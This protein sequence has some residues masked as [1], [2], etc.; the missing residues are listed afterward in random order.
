MLRGQTKSELEAT[1]LQACQEADPQHTGDISWQV[2][3]TILA[4]VNHAV[5]YVLYVF[6]TV[7]I[8]CVNTGKKAC[9]GSQLQRNAC[10]SVLRYIAIVFTSL[11]VAAGLQELHA[12]P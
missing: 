5:I 12:E 2:G 6:C 3:L 7:R 11:Q 4:V 8:V 10:V 9:G 1:F